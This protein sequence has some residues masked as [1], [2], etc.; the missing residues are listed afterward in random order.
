M[1]MRQPLRPGCRPIREYRSSRVTVLARL[2]RAR[3]RVRLTRATVRRYLQA[4]V[5]P[6]RAAYPRLVSKRDPYTAYLTERSA[7]GETN[8]RHLWQELQAQGFTGS[9]MTVMRWA[10]RQQVLLPAPPT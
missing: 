10:Q 5:F 1:P 8:G 4:G 3:P 7:A 2:P 9:V 6:E